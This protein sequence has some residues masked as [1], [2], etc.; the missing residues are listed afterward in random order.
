V[1]E[2]DTRHTGQTLG[3]RHGIGVVHFGQRP[4]PP[5]AQQRHVDGEA[6]AHRPDWCRCCSSPFRGGYAARGWT[7]SARSRVCPRRPPSRRTAGPA[8]GARTFPCRQTARHR[9]RRN[10]RPTP[11]D[12]PSPTTMSAP[13]SPGDL[14]RPSDTG[15][16]T[17][18]ISSA[19]LAW[20]RRCGRKI[21]D[22][23]GPIYPATA[24]R[25]R[26]SHHQSASSMSGHAR[27]VERW[28]RCLQRVPVK[29]GPWSWP[30]SH[31]AGAARPRAPPCARLVTRPAISIASAV[32][33]SRHTSRRWPHRMPVSSRA[34][35]VWNSNRYLQRAL[36]DFRLIG[37]VAGQ[38]LRTLDQMIHRRRD[39]VLVG[40]RAAEEGMVRW[41][42]YSGGRAR[43]NAA[44]PPFR[45]MVG[46]ARNRARQPASA[47]TST[48][49]SS[50][51]AAPMVASMDCRSAG[52][53]G[54]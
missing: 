9:A 39:M 4:Q 46:E 40:A 15:S 49:R 13:I 14:S 24:P 52:V 7:A 32:R 23:P 42:P 47:G 31:N 18:A 3:R 29:C 51:E 30:R 28:G 21:A 22:Q 53:K 43:R 33:S 45:R 27:P 10:C 54:R 5:F 20:R 37:R 17:T 34:T 26:P 25:H 48:K 44:P 2:R 19:P 35:W 38:E 11:I 36:R 8:S 41:R 1:S 6:S 12:W 16:V 50:I